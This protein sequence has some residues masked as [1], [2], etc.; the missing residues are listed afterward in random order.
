MEAHCGFRFTTEQVDEHRRQEGLERVSWFCVMSTF[1]GLHQKLTYSRICNP[2]VTT[3]DGLVQ[4]KCD[5]IN[6]GH[7]W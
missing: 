1:I 7:A 2:V 4:E 6:A 3:K 5:T